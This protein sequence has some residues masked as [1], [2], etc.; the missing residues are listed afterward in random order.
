MRRTV[1]NP[2]VLERPEVIGDRVAVLGASKGAELALTAA[3]LTPRLIGAVVAYSPSAVVFE[4]IG[5]GPRTRRRSRWT[6]E[7]QPLPFVPYSRP[8]RPKIGLRGLSLLP[9]YALA[10]EDRAAAD[11]AAI[12]VEESDAAMLL[13]SGGRD[14]MW[15]SA[16]MSEML[17]QRLADAGKAGQATHVHFEDAGHSFMPWRP[18]FP[19]T[20]ANE[21][22]DRLRLAG[23]GFG[24]DIGGRPAANRAALAEG[25]RLVLKFLDDA[26]GEWASTTASA[27]GH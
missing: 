25:W 21:A 26:L 20:V 3:S 27:K 14:R 7:A 8:M 17:L 23:V 15:P 6:F 4:G 19:L 18:D 11:R 16:A 10:L 9:I 13:L 24:F 5:F 12:P 1:H 2:C 22:V